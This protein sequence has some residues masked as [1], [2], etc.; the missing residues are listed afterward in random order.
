MRHAMRQAGRLDMVTEL[1]GRAEQ[2]QC[3]IVL[4]RG[5]IVALVHYDLTDKTDL[6]L[7]SWSGSVMK[8][9]SHTEKAFAD[10]S[11]QKTE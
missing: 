7:T 6:G 5:V 8:S 11:G 9:C 2:Q 10:P 1:E 4:S 3:H